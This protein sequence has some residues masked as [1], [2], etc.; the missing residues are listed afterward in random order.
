[1]AHAIENRL[2]VA[3]DPGRYLTQIAIVFAAQFA[4]GKIGDVLQAVNKGGIG[5][6]WPASGIALAALLICGYSVWPAVAAGA[7]L[8]VF[9]SSLPHWAAIVYAGGTTLAAV[10]GAFLLER[11]GGFDRIAERFRW[12]RLPD[13]QM[14]AIVRHELR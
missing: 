9:L 1:M 13:L 11:T 4:V 6:V 2:G 8:L 3:S 5:P 10:V 12:R 7:F 14:P